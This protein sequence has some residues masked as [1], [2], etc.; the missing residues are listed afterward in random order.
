MEFKW[1]IQENVP[2]WY[3]L[4]WKEEIPAII[5]KVHKDFIKTAKNFSIETPIINSFMDEFKFSNFSGDLTG[6]FGFD[7]TLFNGTFE[8]IKKNGEFADFLIRI[9]RIKVKIQEVCDH[10]QGSGKDSILEED[11]REC[12]HCGGTGI[13]YI[14]KWQ[15]A[16]AI[17]ASFTV[18]F[19]LTKYPEEETS[20]SI[21]QLMTVETVTNQG[22]H[23]GSLGG[24]ISIPLYQWLSS[25]GE[26]TNLPEVTQAMK[27]AHEYMFGDLHPFDDHCFR[28]YL[29]GNEGGFV[30][31]C[32]GQACGIYGEIWHVP[33]KEGFKLNCH[34]VD[35]PAQQITLLAGLAALHDRAR[36]EIKGYK[37]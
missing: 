31:N 27:I 29:A 24:E 37:I 14:Y 33:K 10:C 11:E 25:L 23:G 19:R 30:A 5:L 26:G 20:A 3:E 15:P 13:A 9:P 7:N 18:F 16:Y 35:S 4:S 17:S 28:A 8:Y 32:P 22:M 6:N 21:P 2:C 12:I 34:N 1:I 36:R